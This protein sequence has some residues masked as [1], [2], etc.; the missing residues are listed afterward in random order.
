MKQEG[1]RDR[2]IRR[3]RGSGSREEEEMELMRHKSVAEQSREHNIRN[4]CGVDEM[5]LSY[6]EDGS[7]NGFR[8]PGEI[9]ARSHW[10]KCECFNPAWVLLF[11]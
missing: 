6:V 7:T 5:R 11:V 9:K 10:N 3:R 1:E 4:P 2:K 8:L